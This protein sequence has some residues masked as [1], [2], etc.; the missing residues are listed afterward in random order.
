M[1][2][3]INKITPYLDVQIKLDAGSR[4]KQP[5]LSCTC[6]SFTQDA[7]QQLQ[8]EELAQAFPSLGSNPLG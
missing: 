3:W 8:K 4:T 1:A 5:A 6:C 2:A 7:V